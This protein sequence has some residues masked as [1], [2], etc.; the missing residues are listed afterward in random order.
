MIWDLCLS[1]PQ[2]A[3]KNGTKEFPRKFNA[4]P[5]RSQKT[6]GMSE[7][8]KKKFSVDLVK[9]LIFCPQEERLSPPRGST[10][11]FSS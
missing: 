2:N 3:E 8:G 4:S 5:I 1:S 6:P 9:A 11:N 7:S 10:R